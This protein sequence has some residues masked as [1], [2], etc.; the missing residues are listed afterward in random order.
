[1]KKNKN[2]TARVVQS[3]FLVPLYIHWRAAT[4]VYIVASLT[5]SSKNKKPLSP[6]RWRGSNSLF[7]KSKPSVSKKINSFPEAYFP[8]G[9]GH[10]VRGIF[11]LVFTVDCKSDSLF[12]SCKLDALREIFLLYDT[13]AN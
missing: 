3:V 8:V 2:N 9:T 11:Q 4:L 12:F 7:L 5:A 13:V 1:M 10:D 6:W